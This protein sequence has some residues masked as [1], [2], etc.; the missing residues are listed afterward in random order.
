M[1]GFGKFKRCVIFVLFELKNLFSPLKKSTKSTFFYHKTDYYG[2]KSRIKIEN[3]MNLCVHALRI[4]D[5]ATVASISALVDVV[6]LLS[7]P[8][9]VVQTS[10]LDTRASG[11]TGGTGVASV[12]WIQVVAPHPWIART[13]LLALQIVKKETG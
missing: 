2:Q 5:A 6:A 7:G 9:G 13:R 11:E 10:A 3:F 4:R 1:L 12:A 8:P